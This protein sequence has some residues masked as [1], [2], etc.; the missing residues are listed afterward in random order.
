MGTELF[1][2]RFGQSNKSRK[3]SKKEIYKNPTD[4]PTL[5]LKRSFQIRLR[6]PLKTSWGCPEPTSQ[7]RSFDV[8]FRRPLNVV[9]RR[10]QDVRSGR[11]WDVSSG[12]V[13]S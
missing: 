4:D 1:L 9:L 7:G 12:P 2:D 5:A 10:L 3:K 13:G 11:P 6:D 8:R